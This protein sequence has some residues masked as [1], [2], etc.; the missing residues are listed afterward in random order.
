MVKAKQDRRKRDIKSKLM[1]AIAMLLVSSIMM[2]SSTYAWFT[3]STAPEVTGISTAVGANGNLEMALLPL[4]GLTTDIGNADGTQTTVQETNVTWGN[5]VDLSNNSFYGLEEIVLYP[6]RLTYDATTGVDANGNVTAFDASASLSTPTYGYDGRV[7]GIVKNTMS[8]VYTNGAF[9]ATDALQYGVRAIGTSTSMTAQQA[10]YRTAKNAGATAMEKAKTLAKQALASNGSVLANTA[11]IRGMDKTATYT[12][13]QI[14]AMNALVNELYKTNGVMDQID[15]AYVQYIYAYAISAQGVQTEAEYTL[16]KAVVDSALGITLP[17]TEDGTTYHTRA[18]YLLAKLS[19][20]IGDGDNKTTITIPVSFSTP[21]TALS[22]TRKNVNSAYTTLSNVTPTADSVDG[23][24]RYNWSDFSSALYLLVDTDTMKV[25]DLPIG[26]IM[27]NQQTLIDSYLAEQRL[28]MTMG[29]GC[30]VFADVADHCG[31]YDAGITI[32]GVTVKGIALNNVPATMETES[33]MAPNYYLVVVNAAF[34]SD[35]KPAGDSSA[36]QSLTNFYGYVVDLA[37]RTNAAGVAGESDLLLQQQ[38]VDRI[39]AESP[40]VVDD[41][42]GE[43]TMG[44]G[45]S[46][47]FSSSSPDFS[48]AQVKALMKSIRIVFF[49]PGSTTNTVLATAKLDVDNGELTT[50]GWKAYMYLYKTEVEVTGYA[51]ATYAANSGLTY[52]TKTTVDET[53]TYTAVDDATAAAAAAGTLYT[54]TTQKKE[55][56]Y[57]GD[58]AVITKLVQNEAKQV[59]VL[60]Y[61]DGDSVQNKDVAASGTTSMTGTMNL[62]FASNVDL[63]PMDYADLKGEAATNNTQTQG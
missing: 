49:T 2:V 20:G 62:Q 63:K 15:N 42:T 21:L 3:L 59:S 13:A 48:E 7:D 28:W 30:G 34:T 27:D 24:V 35:M 38:G 22:T 36:N 51:E 23:E 33:G 16:V 44:G 55:V 18:Q 58:D 45:S 61:L 8:S 1:A 47:T 11:I 10:A 43:T 25:N 4:S 52:Y 39:Y 29:S 41:E 5:L 60:V 32:D 14:D 9:P 31:D 26:T 12:Q 19:A 56:V 37:F 40:G 54:A 6:S 53:D 50:D 46:M 17:Y 57:N